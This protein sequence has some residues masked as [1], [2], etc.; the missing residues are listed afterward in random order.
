MRRHRGNDRRLLAGLRRKPEI[1]SERESA[2]DYYGASMK[3]PNIDAGRR[4]DRLLKLQLFWG[5]TQLTGWLLIILGGIAISMTMRLTPD[6]L[7]GR[8]S[9]NPKLSLTIVP[10]IT[11]PANFRILGA[12]L[13]LLGFVLVSFASMW[14]RKTR[15]RTAT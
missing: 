8:L 4:L 11:A 14:K 7:A 2:K 12:A 13:L 3:P 10:W 15:S 6:Q 9:T 5:T 1:P